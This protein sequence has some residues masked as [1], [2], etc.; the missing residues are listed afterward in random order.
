MACWGQPAAVHMWTILFMWLKPVARLFYCVCSV[1]C[2]PILAQQVLQHGWGLLRCSAGVPDCLVF[3]HG[4][5]LPEPQLF[6]SLQH[7]ASTAVWVIWSDFCELPGARNTHTLFYLLVEFFSLR[8]AWLTRS[9]CSSNIGALTPSRTAA[10]SLLG[11]G[12]CLHFL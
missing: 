2:W 10:V 5:D 7:W 3:V 1:L 4:M 8:Y 11:H 9:H 6:L 12:C